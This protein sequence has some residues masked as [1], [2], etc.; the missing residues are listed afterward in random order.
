MTTTGYRFAWVSVGGTLIITGGL[1]GSVTAAPDAL[2][3]QSC[4][5]GALGF[6]IAGGVAFT[7]CNVLKTKSQTTPG[8][9]TWLVLTTGELLH[10]LVTPVAGTNLHFTIAGGNYHVWWKVC[11]GTTL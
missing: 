9:D 6:I 11:V 5:T 1:V 4:A 8:D 3:G 2:S 10:Q 7:Q